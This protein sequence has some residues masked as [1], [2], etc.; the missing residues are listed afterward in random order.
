[1][2]IHLW[3]VPTIMVPPSA[4]ESAKELLRAYLSDV[5]DH[6][7]PKAERSPGH[8]VRMLVEAIACGWFVRRIADGARVQAPQEPEQESELGGA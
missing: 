2:Q 3:N 4:A 8:I 5:Q 7:Q 1:M 6:L